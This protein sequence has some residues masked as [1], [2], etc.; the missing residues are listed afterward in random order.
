[1]RTPEPLEQW[2]SALASYLSNR[3]ALG[4][5]YRHEEWLLRLITEHLANVG[6]IDLDRPGFEVWRRTVRHRSPNTRHRYERIVYNFCRY[7]R[8]REPD[9][10]VPDPHSLTRR[11]PAAPPTLIDAEQVRRMIEHVAGWRPRRPNRLRPAAVRLSILLFY[12]TGMRSGE[13]R[14]MRLADVDSRQGV[15]FIRDSKFRKSR[16]LPLSTSVQAELRRYLGIRRGFGYDDAANSPLICHAKGSGYTA[17]GIAN[18]V[19]A[20]MIGAGV[21]GP[22]G[23]VPRVHDFRHSFAV[24]ALQR[25]YDNG[26]D[27]QAELPK[28]A[29]YMGHVSIVSTAYYLRL[30]SAVMRSANERFEHAY[31][32]VLTGEA[33]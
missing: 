32:R 28:L 1:M 11:C 22:D 26:A 6:A 8:R 14:R 3:R 15:L 17:E 10:F 24:A 30:M 29:L 13:L 18:C 16:W 21:Y 33:P 4:R 25:W 19:K 31:A 12:T 20:A 2:H 5:G 7:R 23:R 9:C 27:V